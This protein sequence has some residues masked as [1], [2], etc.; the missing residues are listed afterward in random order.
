M[1]KNLTLQARKLLSDGTQI[2]YLGLGVY[3]SDAG[4][5]TYDSALDAL[6]KGYRHIDT[7]QLYGNEEDVGRAVRDSGIPRSEVWVTTKVWHS[8]FGSRDRTIAS[9][10][11]SLKRM[12]LDYVDLLLLH[13]PPSKALR[14]EVWKTLELLQREGKVKSIG[15]SNYGVHHLKEMESY[16]TVKPSVNQVEISPYLTR[17][18][19]VNYCNEHQIAVEAYSPLTKGK[20]LDD[21]KLV[22]IAQKYNVS[23]AQLLIRYG[24]E[25]DFITLPKSVTPARIEANSKVFH[26][27]IEKADLDALDA[28]NVNLSK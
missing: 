4:G 5:E 18:D 16:A 11:K 26:F 22:Q 12:G 6:R 9:L 2:P 3:R 19:I 8:N 23:T 25:H 7:A 1:A 27:A 20:K 15:V 17:K 24:L 14:A 21:P 28:F 13:C 10:D